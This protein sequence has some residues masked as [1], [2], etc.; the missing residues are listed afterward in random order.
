MGVHQIAAGCRNHGAEDDGS[1]E[2]VT[3]INVQSEAALTCM[4]S[5]VT[6]HLSC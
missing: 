2:Q 1:P 5:F 4:D 6:F 3:G